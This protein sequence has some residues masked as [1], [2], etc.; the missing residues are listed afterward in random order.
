MM[1]TEAHRKVRRVRWACR[2]AAAFCAGGMMASAWLTYATAQEHL[3]MVLL[4]G[5]GIMVFGALGGMWNG[6]QA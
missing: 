1:K 6:G 5:I 2:V 4:A 3:Q